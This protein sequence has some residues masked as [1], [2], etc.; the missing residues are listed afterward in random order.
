M[1]KDQQAL[2]NRVGAE[3]RDFVKRLLSTTAFSA[4]LALTAAT[5]MSREAAAQSASSAQSST[6]GGGSS[7]QSN[8]LAVPEPATL[9]LVGLGLAGAALAARK[10][11]SEND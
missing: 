2:L 4:P 5:L 11:K 7:Q 10:A 1:P 9:S 8:A 6:P 3:R